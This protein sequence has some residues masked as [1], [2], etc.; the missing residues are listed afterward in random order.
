MPA[1]ADMTLKSDVSEYFTFLFDVLH[2]KFGIDCRLKN[3]GCK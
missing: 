1:L 2:E 3:G